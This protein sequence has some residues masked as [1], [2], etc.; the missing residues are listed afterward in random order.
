MKEGLFIARKT[1]LIL[2]AILVLFIVRAI[3]IHPSPEKGICLRDD[4]DI[5]EF[6]AEY[7]D[8]LTKEGYEPKIGGVMYSEVGEGDKI[9]KGYVVLFK[10]NEII[11]PVIVLSQ[12]RKDIL[13]IGTEIKIDNKENVQDTINFVFTSVRVLS[14]ESAQTVS[15]AIRPVAS[16]PSGK[17]S[18]YS[19]KMNRTYVV[20]RTTV[21]SKDVWAITAVR[22]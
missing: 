15:D 22:R 6:V 11:H 5:T 21:N 17:G 20:G 7:N 19:Q 16:N 3:V 18:F 8:I 12:D 13:S 10:E 4:M 9:E 1:I 2:F 14:G